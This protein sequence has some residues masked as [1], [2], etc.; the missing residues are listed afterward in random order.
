MPL[1]ENDCG[2]YVCLDFAPARGGKKGQVIEWWARGGA[3]RVLADSFTEWLESLF[4][5]APTADSSSPRK[6]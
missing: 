5:E 2:D 3:R 1:T 4:P 6:R